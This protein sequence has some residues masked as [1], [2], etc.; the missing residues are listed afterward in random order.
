MYSRFIFHQL[1]HAPRA[2]F[3]A[4]P[5]PDTAAFNSANN[6]IPVLPPAVQVAQRPQQEHSAHANIHDIHCFPIFSYYE[7]ILYQC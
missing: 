7:I 4:T 3:D 5:A 6:L 1:Q 2:P